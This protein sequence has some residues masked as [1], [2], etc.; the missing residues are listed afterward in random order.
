MERAGKGE[1]RVTE[2]ARDILH[3]DSPAQ[4][5]ARIREAASE[6]SLFRELGERFIGV[7]PPEDGVVSFLHRQGF[8]P[9]A[10][11]PAAQAFL[12]TMSYLEELGGSGSHGTGTPLGAESSPVKIG[13]YVQWTSGGV[14]QFSIP[15][16][17]VAIF[18]DGKHAQVHGSP[19]GVPMSELTVVEAPKPKPTFAGGGSSTVI[20][21]SGK[22][23][24]DINILMSGQR[25]QI[26]A[27]VDLDGVAKLK[28]ALTKYEE[29]LKILQ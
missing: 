27:D 28:E 20:H 22:T 29:L 19:G 15:R 1:T 4:R 2:R 23:P 25:L 12:E 11:R 13:D 5:L 16:K 10:V 26:T 21:E 6:P 14:D 9:N 24:P 18:E 8:N 3:P 17:V 7:V